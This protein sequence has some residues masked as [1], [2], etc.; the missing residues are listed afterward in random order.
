MLPLP[1][2]RPSEGPGKGDFFMGPLITSNFVTL[3]STQFTQDPQRAQARIVLFMGS[4]S[5]SNSVTL[6]PPLFTRPLEGQG[7]LILFSRVFEFNSN[8]RAGLIFYRRGVRSVDN[9]GNKVNLTFECVMCANL[10]QGGWLR[11]YMQI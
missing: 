5:T 4:L 6:S 1:F 7:R 8:S 2:T 11:L 10:K 9:K 3:S